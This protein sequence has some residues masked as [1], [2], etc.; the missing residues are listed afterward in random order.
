MT[1]NRYIYLL[2]ILS[3]LSSFENR[4]AKTSKHRILKE[5]ALTKF[6]FYNDSIYVNKN[7]LSD[8][9]LIT[10]KEGVFVNYDISDSSKIVRKI[11]MPVDKEI[12]E[13]SGKYVRINDLSYVLSKNH[14][15]V[16]FYDELFSR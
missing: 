6:Y 14:K 16:Y 12:L 15:K 3:T 11:I 4:G 10:I 2:I 5:L 9:V 13:I 7:F 8:K 1:I